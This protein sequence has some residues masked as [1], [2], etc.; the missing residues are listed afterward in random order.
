[1]GTWDDDILIQMCADD[2]KVANKLEVSRLSVDDWED[3]TEVD[4][5]QQEIHVTIVHDHG[6]RL[7]PGLCFRLSVTSAERL[8]R[9]LQEAIERRARNGQA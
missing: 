8:V 5:T 2:G 4:L 3:G 1:M 7:G 9:E 6:P